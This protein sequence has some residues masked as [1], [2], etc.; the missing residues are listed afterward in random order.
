MKTPNSNQRFALSKALTATLCLSIAL[1]AL[2]AYAVTNELV[3]SAES[4]S[5]E[6]FNS[7]GAWI[8]SFASTGPYYPVGIAAS[9]TTGD[10]FAVTLTGVVLRY[11]KTGASF[12]PNGSYWSTFD[13]SAQIG[14]N[15][16]EALLFDPSGNLYVATNF[17]E[18]ADGYTVEIYGFSATQLTKETPV[19]SGTPI[20]TAIEQGGQMA[21]DA[22]KNLCMASWFSPQTVQCF[23]TNTGALV[24]DYASEIQAQVIQPTG[25]AFSPSNILTVSSLFTGEVYSEAAAR[26][27][28]M[29]LLATGTVQPS[30]VGFLAADSAGNLYLPEWH[31]VGARYGGSGNDYCYYYSCQDTDT[32]SD[33]VYKVD[34]TTGVIINFISNHLWGPYQMIFVSF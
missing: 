1:L 4:H 14:Y 5:I 13:M 28:P 26:V 25:L 8:Q 20:I 11:T 21:W 24:F 33:I 17:G 23:N 12:G 30:D 10:V 27:G 15:A 6:K 31:N 22:D 9:P 29:N 34:P 16:L 18:S 19:S 2:P 32:S 7:K 3:G